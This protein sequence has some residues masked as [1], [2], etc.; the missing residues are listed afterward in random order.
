MKDIILKVTDGWIEP[1][2]L[3]RLDPSTTEIYL[4][5]IDSLLVDY[6]HKISN[7]D[8]KKTKDALEVQYKTKIKDI[9]AS[10]KESI[11]QLKNTIE[12]ERKKYITDLNK[13]IEFIRRTENDRYNRQLESNNKT[14]ESL[15]YQ[16]NDVLLKQQTEQKKFN[17]QI[18]DVYNNVEQEINNKLKKEYEQLYSSKIIEYNTTINHLKEEVKKHEIKLSEIPTITSII[19]EESDKQRQAL[20]EFDNKLEPLYKLYTGTNEE[21]GRIAEQTIT[22]YLSNEPRYTDAIINNVSGET[23]VGDIHMQWNG[24]KCLIEVKNKK[25]LT[26]DDMRKFER[27]V[28]NTSINSS[29]NCAVFVSLRS[30][31][32]PGKTREVIQMD[33]VNNIPVI[34]TYI[35]DFSLLYYSFICLKSVVDNVVDNSNQHN[36]LVSYYQSYMKKTQHLINYFNKQIKAHETSIR[37]LKKELFTLTSLNEELVSNIE[38]YSGDSFT[39]LDSIDDILEVSNTHD[40]NSNIDNKSNHDDDNSD[41]DVNS[42]DD[43]NNDLNLNNKEES[44]NKIVTYFIKHTI[45]HKT[46]PSSSDILQK[47]NITTYQLLRKLSGIKDIITRAKKRY[48]QQTITSDMIKNIL[49]YKTSNNEWPKRPLLIK[50]FIPRRLLTKIGYV[51]KTKKV[52]ETIYEF[53]E[54]TAVNVDV[55]TEVET[56]PE[57][58]PEVEPDTEP[59]VEPEVEAEVEAPKPLIK[60]RI[61]R[62]GINK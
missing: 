10:H 11:N 29:I 5:C 55:E 7:S 33:V 35:T 60:K 26:V 41:D 37:S 15:Q 24:L 22:E 40:D 27:D 44:I 43:T 21:K 51:L 39:M 32:F 30:N 16:L 31:D 42:D 14:I 34:Y 47:F 4:D 13:E 2:S 61:R 38:L 23:A 57:V 18:S 52:M 48:L 56:E 59:E 54:N 1:A 58:E 36:K 19:K 62:I 49:L 53:I 28:Q 25:K 8:I 46:H 6:S 50:K 17:Q 45:K 12:E 20:S 9:I 3:K